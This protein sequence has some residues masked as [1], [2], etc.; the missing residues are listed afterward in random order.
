MVAA[1]LKYR[2]ARQALID[3][4]VHHGVP[5]NT[6]TAEL[7]QTVLTTTTAKLHQHYEMD[8]WVAVPGSVSAVVCCTRAALAH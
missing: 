3:A 7:L 8:S 6:L 2:P 1:G 4:A 5:G